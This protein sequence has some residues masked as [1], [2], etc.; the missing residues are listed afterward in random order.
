MT[1]SH[2]AFAVRIRGIRGR[3]TW[4]LRAYGNKRDTA[5]MRRRWLKDGNACGPLTKI[6]LPTS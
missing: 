3:C 5:H 6:R 4:Q 2:W 1:T